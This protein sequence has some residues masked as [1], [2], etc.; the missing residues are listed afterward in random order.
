MFGMHKY[1]EDAWKNG[2]Y[3]DARKRYFNAVYRHVVEQWWE[4]GEFLDKESKLPHLAHGIC[5]LMFLLWYELKYR[6]EN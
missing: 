1:E 4:N 5:C 2:D 3:L 6:V